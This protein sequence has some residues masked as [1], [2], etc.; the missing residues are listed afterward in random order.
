MFLMTF[1][2]DIYL[3]IYLEREWEEGQRERERDNLK[4]IPRCGAQCGAQSRDPK[5]TTLAK[6]T[7]RMLNN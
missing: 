2:T 1:S 3:F 7:R 5:I 6:T 4:Q